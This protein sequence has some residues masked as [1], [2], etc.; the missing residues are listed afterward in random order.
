M[1]DAM[2]VLVRS[3]MGAAAAACVSAPAVAESAADAA[4]IRALEQE[5]AAAWSAHDARR[6]AALFTDD[7]DV[8]NVLGWHWK[9]RTELEQK[10]ARAYAMVFA[11]SQ[12]S[13]HDVAVRFIRPDV[14]IAHVPWTMT[15]ALSPTGG[16]TAPQ[17]G[18]Q[19]QTLVKQS[20]QWR[21]AAFQNTNAMPERDFPNAK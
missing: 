17:Q 18:L 3:I 7:A 19:T 16:A 15:G 8:V 13:V 5:Q 14:A 21:I 2:R 20:G 10:L 1:E 4:Q 11:K 9:G 6:Y 12:L